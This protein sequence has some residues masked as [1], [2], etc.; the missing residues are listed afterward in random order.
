VDEVQPLQWLNCLA[1][2]ATPF[3]V[4]GLDRRHVVSGL[5]QSTASRFFNR[6]FDAARPHGLVNIVER[7]PATP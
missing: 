7:G 4:A 2:S 6:F 5:R 3:A 1:A